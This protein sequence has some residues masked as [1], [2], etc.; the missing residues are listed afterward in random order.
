[1]IAGETGHPHAT[2][3]RTL[4]RAGISR[5]PREP[6]ERPRLYE[7]PC[8]GDL[9]HIDSK[10]FVRFSRPGHAVTGDRFT[11]GAE[12]RAR[13]GYEWVHSIVDDHSRYAYSEL[14]RDERAD[15][16]TGFVE[17]ALAHLAEE[18]IEPKRL[19]S[20]NAFVYRHNRSLGELLQAHEIE[21]RFIR[22]RRPQTNGK[23]ERYQQTLKR[24]WG[25]GRVYRSSEHRAK[26]LSHW[27]GYY[28]TRRPH[29][30]IGGRPRSESATQPSPPH[31]SLRS[32]TSRRT[33]S[34]AAAP[35]S[36]LKESRAS[37]RSS[38]PRSHATHPI[39]TTPSNAFAASADSNSPRSSA[40]C[41]RPQ[42]IS[43]LSFS[44]DSRSAL[45]RSPPTASNQ[46]CATT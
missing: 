39:S 38:P 12:K 28:N 3:W 44:T 9:L 33:R 4:N 7:W 45:R 5:P 25:L 19:L 36:T 16:V 18:G 42:R 40:H 1:L 41:S 27:L 35:D 17:R 34:A 32:P 15:T 37:K 24:E 29:S 31:C 11:S 13:I 20:D 21:H 23:V 30:S 46:R 14:H 10:R 26:A 2:V 8:P 6:R 43:A 22:P